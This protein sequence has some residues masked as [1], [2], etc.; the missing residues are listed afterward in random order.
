MDRMDKIKLVYIQIRLMQKR[1]ILMLK[2]S[3]ILP[4]S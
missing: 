3:G 1:H 4:V 2:G